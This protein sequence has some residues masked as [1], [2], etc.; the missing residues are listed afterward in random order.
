MG[1]GENRVQKGTE[2]LRW[3]AGLGRLKNFDWGSDGAG[4]AGG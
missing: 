2:N 1:F 4:G 3:C